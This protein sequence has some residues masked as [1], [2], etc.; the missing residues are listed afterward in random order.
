MTAC[1][2]AST[3]AGRSPTSSWTTGASSR[4]RP[5]RTTRRTSLRAALD[6]VGAGASAEL[7]AHGTTVATNALLEGRGGRVALVTTQGFADVIEIARQV[8]PS[9]YDPMADRPRPLVDRDLR[10]EVGG[11]LDG[12]GREIEGLD[13]SSIPAV[14]GRRGCGR[15]VPS[16]RRP[17]RRPRAAR[18]QGARGA[19]A[20]CDVLARGVA[21]VPGVRTCSHDRRQRGSAPGVPRLPARARRVGARSARDDVRRRPRAGGRRGRATGGAAAVGAGRRRAGGG[22]RRI[23][24][25]LSRRGLVRHGGHEH[26]RVPR[27]RRRARAGAVA[28]RRRI[29]DPAAG[30]RHPH[31]RCRWR[32]DRATRRRWRPRRRPGERGRRPRPRLLRTRRREGDGDGRRSRARAHPRRSRVPRSRP[33]RRGGGTERARSGTTS[34]RTA[35]WQWSTPPWSARFA[36]SRSSAASMR[37]TSH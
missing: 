33:T 11:R 27:A 20:G 26:G 24:V 16:P 12:H 31:D 30:P 1:D 15:G 35:S 21:R 37:A 28:D 3:R 7:L 5:R 22:G 17:R 9:L 2:S 32:I 14:P 4:C 13:P 29:S 18:R 10:V 19:G 23:G 34:P 25:R 8:R 6:D 36:W